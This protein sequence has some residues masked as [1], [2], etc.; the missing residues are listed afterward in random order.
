M[1]RSLTGAIGLI[2]VGGADTASCFGNALPTGTEISLRAKNIVSTVLGTKK[3]R[4]GS[5]LTAFIENATAFVAARAGLTKLNGLVT[6]NP[7]GRAKTFFFFNGDLFTS[8]TDISTNSQTLR[9]NRNTFLLGP[10]E[11]A[12]GHQINNLQAKPC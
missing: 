12:I 4:R 7:L 5:D 9:L 3:T 2:D 1:I 11:N 6:F 8:Q 10:F